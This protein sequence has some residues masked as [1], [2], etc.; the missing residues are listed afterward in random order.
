MLLHHTH[1]IRHEQGFTLLEVLLVIALMAIVSVGVVLNLDLAGPEQKLER[2][3]T[4]F[5]AVV[6]MAAEQALMRG[7]EYGMRVDD[8]Q[9]RFFQLDEENKWQPIEDD[10]LFAPRNWPDIIGAKLTLDDLPWEQENKLTRSGSMFEGVEI[11]REK[12]EERPQVLIFS[13]GDVT[14]FSVLLSLQDVAD[15]DMA[16]FRINGFDTGEIQIEGPLDRP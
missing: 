9:Y 10:R 7:E 3:A 16:Y 2:E 1:P 6:E 8:K 11:E 13:S 12:K 4:R 5:G 15:D 14:P